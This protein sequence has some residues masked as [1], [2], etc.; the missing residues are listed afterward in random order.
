MSFETIRMAVENGVA[1]IELNSPPV[2]AITPKMID[3]LEAA[4]DGLLQEE[5][6]RAVIV[7]SAMEK[8]FAAGADI[9]QFLHGGPAETRAISTRGVAVF[10][11][12]AAFPQPVICAINGVAFGGGLELALFCDFRVIDP[13][14]KVG[15]TEAGLGIIPGYGGTQ[16]LTRLVGPGMARRM[17]F[18]GQVI[19]GEEAYRI[20]LAE[21]LSAPGECLA[22]AKKIASQIAQ[23]AP[24]AVA[25]EKRCVA[26][27]TSHDLEVGL[28]Y[29]MNEGYDIFATED[30]SEG[31]AA[32]LEKRDAVFHG[33]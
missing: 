11:K 24:L 18:T 12:I 10:Q 26:F 25:S 3:E 21:V 32:F 31:A 1:V 15:L 6:L 5:G 2:N 17:L 27:A 16:T 23:K 13:R 14:A 8:S 22:E 9:N 28:P 4:F 30:K 19:K 20:G 29:E 7:G 33:K